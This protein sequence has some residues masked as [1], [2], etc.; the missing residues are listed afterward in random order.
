MPIALYVSDV[1]DHHLYLIGEDVCGED[2]VGCG[3]Y[4][5]RHAAL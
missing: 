2:E 5:C 3:A 1:C 4:L